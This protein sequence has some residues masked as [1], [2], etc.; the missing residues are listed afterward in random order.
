M[1]N[2]QL[3]TSR[4]NK[5]VITFQQHFVFNIEIT[6]NQQTR[7]TRKIQRKAFLFGYSPTELII[8]TW[9]R[10]CSHIPLQE[11]TQIRKAMML[12]KW[13]H[14][15]GSTVFMLT[16]SET[17]KDRSFLRAEKYGDLTTTE[18]KSPQ[19][20]TWISEQSPTRCRGPSSR[21]S[22]ESV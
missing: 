12:H 2:G 4:C 22:L 10:M 6:V 5:T 19:R 18:H 14:K 21:H 3:S 7:R 11:R 13:R 1:Y 16:S 17:E 20:R 15:N 8:R 9:K